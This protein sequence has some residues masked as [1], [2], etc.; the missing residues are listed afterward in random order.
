VRART[1]IVGEN[2]FAWGVS[3]VASVI[4]GVDGLPVPARGEDDRCPDPSRAHLGWKL[5]GVSRIAW[6]TAGAI[7]IAAVADSTKSSD[8]AAE[9]WV[10]G[11]HPKSLFIVALEDTPLLSMWGILMS[12]YRF[13][14]NRLSV[15]AV[16]AHVV[17][18]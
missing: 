2:V 5:R 11:N 1:G 7:A 15:P 10:S 13:E 12:L 8:L 17:N 16:G 9:L 18:G 14:S 4:R 6:S 3:D